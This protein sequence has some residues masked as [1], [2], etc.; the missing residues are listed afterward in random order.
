MKDDILQ[1]SYELL[2][3]YVARKTKYY[4]PPCDAVQVPESAVT[5]V[6]VPRLQ[7]SRVIFPSF[8]LKSTA[9]LHQRKPFLTLI[10]RQMKWQKPPPK[11]TGE[12][13]DR[14]F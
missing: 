2:L 9:S 10:S 4:T 7:T 1:Y 5:A 3:R 8:D 11:G 13:R 6:S 14:I 12:K